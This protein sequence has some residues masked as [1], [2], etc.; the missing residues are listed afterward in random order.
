MMISLVSAV[1]LDSADMLLR[2][3]GGLGI[4][5]YLISL[6]VCVSAYVSFLQTD[7]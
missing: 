6:Q 2:A 5:E 7:S 3:L 1:T 4:L